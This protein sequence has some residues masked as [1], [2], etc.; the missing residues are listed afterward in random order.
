MKIHLSFLSLIFII[1][2][3]VHPNPTESNPTGND[4]PVINNIFIDPIF[5]TV[6]STTTITVDATDPNGDDLSYSWTVALGDIIGSGNQ[7]KYT[8][9]FCCVGTNTVHV[10]VKDSRGATTKGSIDIVVNP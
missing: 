1:A 5:I 7:V 10:G 2:A 9:A 8:A 6:G 4:S 3:C